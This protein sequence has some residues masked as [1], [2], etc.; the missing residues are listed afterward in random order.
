MN[1]IA[2]NIALPLLC[3]FVLPVIHAGSPLVSRIM[4]PFVLLAMV[5]FAA[6][7]FGR[8]SRIRCVCTTTD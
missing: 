6:S 7:C 1:N 4:G 5:W 3:A 2:F 8:E